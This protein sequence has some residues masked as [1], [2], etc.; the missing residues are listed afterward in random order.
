MNTCTITGRLP[1]LDYKPRVSVGQECVLLAGELC[2][3]SSQAVPSV[4]LLGVASGSLLQCG[5]RRLTRPP[6]QGHFN[7]VRS[8][9]LR[10][11]CLLPDLKDYFYKLITECCFH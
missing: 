11:K 2:E 1:G 5:S 9:R 7:P 3:P 10:G 6:S 8:P 4:L